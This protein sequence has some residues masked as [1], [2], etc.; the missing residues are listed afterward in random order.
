M[1]YIRN[2]RTGEVVFVPDAPQSVPVGPQN[3]TYPLQAPKMQAD[4][5]NTQANTS[6]TNVSTQKTQQEIDQAAALFD[7]QKR[8]ADAKALLAHYQA[9]QAE[10]EAQQKN[11]L[12]PQSIQ[13]LSADAMAKLQT[14]DRIRNSAGAAWLP[15]VG[16]GAET[17][18][19]IGGTKAHDVQAD[20]GSLKAGGAL[21]EV[22]KLSQA[23]GRN[24]LSPMSNSDVELIAR[25]T[26]NLDQGQ[27]PTNF[28]SNLNNYQGAYTRAYAGA[29]G[30]RTLN[31][32]IERLM[33]TIPPE[34]REA[35][36][37]EALRQYNERVSSMN[38]GNRPP[39]A[40]RQRSSGARFLGW[41]N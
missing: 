15:A 3:P 22:L 27:T 24:P 13:G 25:N 33:P 17:A 28:N 2:K 30:L 39:R 19:G 10:A 26:A 40:Q 16:F 5:G 32:E 9:Q 23:T 38:L 35:F 29:E 4:I 12:N 8:E 11:P 1:G 34:K 6:H 37:Q 7:A 14:I 20:L 31:S 18:A 21:S 41:E 36:K